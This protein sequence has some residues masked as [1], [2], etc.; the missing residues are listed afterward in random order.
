M[1]S[2]YS[3]SSKSVPPGQQALG[4][5]D[6]PEV[7]EAPVEGGAGADAGVRQLID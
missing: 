5:V 1:T 6:H 4:G 3:R 7:A 2:L